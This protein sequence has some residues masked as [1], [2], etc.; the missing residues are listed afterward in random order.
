MG[1]NLAKSEKTLVRLARKMDFLKSES[2]LLRLEKDFLKN[3]KTFLRLETDLL[4]IEKMLLR[5]E[6]EDFLKSEK[7]LWKPETRK[8]LRNSERSWRF[9]IESCR[10]YDLELILHLDESTRG[11]TTSQR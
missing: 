11:K 10:C 9:Y 2:T 6:G 3:E 5:L 1:R 8:D 4:E 7:T